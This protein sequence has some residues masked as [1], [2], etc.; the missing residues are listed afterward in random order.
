M[1]H[2]S[3]CESASA[4]AD[5]VEPEEM[6][7]DRSRGEGGESRCAVGCDGNVGGGWC[8]KLVICAFV[9]VWVGRLPVLWALWGVQVEVVQALLVTSMTTAD[10]YELARHKVSPR[11]ASDPPASRA[12]Y[13]VCYCPMRAIDV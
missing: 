2:P 12:I 3:A 4:P 1:C 7:P 11:C 10:V 8:A 9:H 13:L 6:A 5:D